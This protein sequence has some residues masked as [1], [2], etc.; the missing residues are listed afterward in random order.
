MKMFRTAGR[1]IFVFA[2]M[3]EMG[4]E[5]RHSH[6]AVADLALDAGICHLFCFG[7]ESFHT[8]MRARELHIPDVRHF[9]NKQ[10]LAEQLLQLSKTDDIILLKGSRGMALEEII[11]IMKGS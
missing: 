10:D 11:Q 1:K 9:E 7:R 4:V 3:L 8:A 6:K 5:S 2:D